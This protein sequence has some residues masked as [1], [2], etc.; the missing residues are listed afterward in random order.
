MEGLAV[1]VFCSQT[2]R[3]LRL[4]S[5]CGLCNATNAT[6]TAAGMGRM[7]DAGCGARTKQHRRCVLA[8]PGQ[9]TTVAPCV[10][11]L[12]IA[13]QTEELSCARAHWCAGHRRTGSPARCWRLLWWCFNDWCAG[14]RRTDGP[15]QPLRKLSL[16]R[17]HLASKN[18]AFAKNKGAFYARQ[19]AKNV[20]LHVT[21]NVR[22][23]RQTTA[24]TLLPKRHNLARRCLSA[25]WR[26]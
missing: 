18:S 10:E 21:A 19:L 9:S 15:A 22:H 7:A 5:A 11:A 26:G 23:E 20:R 8:G 2:A 1:T 16:P 12:I 13:A 24:H 4:R 6:H 3:W 14:R 17:T 25:R